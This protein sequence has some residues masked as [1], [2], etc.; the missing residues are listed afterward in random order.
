MS[1]GSKL[2]FFQGGWVASVLHSNSSPEHPPS[3]GTTTQPGRVD[4]ASH[5]QET[6]GLPEPSWNHTPS[7]ALRMLP[8]FKKNHKGEG[9]LQKIDWVPP[10]PFFHPLAPFCSSDVNILL[11]EPWLIPALY[12]QRVLST[13]N[14][15]S[16]WRNSA[17]V[18]ETVLICSYNQHVSTGDLQCSR[19][20]R[21]HR[22]ID[23]WDSLSAASKRTDR[24]LWWWRLGVQWERRVIASLGGQGRWGDADHFSLRDK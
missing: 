14:L 15:I 3:H 22:Y 11:L 20:R 24:W 10:L 16:I 12:R 21:R 7:F 2:P 23:N 9:N 4:W 18:E 19:P 5:S 13:G 1:D 8:G 17:L 6:P